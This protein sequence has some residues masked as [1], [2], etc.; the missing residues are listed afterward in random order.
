VDENKSETSVNKSVVAIEACEDAV[1]IEL[2][3]EAAKGLFGFIRGVS[4][5]KRPQVAWD[6]Y[7]AIGAAIGAPGAGNEPRQT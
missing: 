3:P 5:N 6:V 7:K 4:A 2:T 1:V